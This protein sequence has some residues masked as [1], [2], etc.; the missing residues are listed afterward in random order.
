MDVCVCVCMLE[1]QY[2]A[3]LQHQ[4]SA[5][6]P[7]SSLSK[8]QHH[9]WQHQRP[10]LPPRLTQQELFAIAADEGG[11]GAWSFTVAALEVYN[12]S[13]H[14]LLAPGAAT[15]TVNLELSGLPPGELPPGIGR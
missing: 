6:S 1:A 2:S 13:V 7:C 4:L 3:P 9:Q 14:D 5:W 15:N 11:T 12:E 10:V 8:Q